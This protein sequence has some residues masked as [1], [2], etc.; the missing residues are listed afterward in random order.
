MN[1]SH[2]FEPHDPT[3]TD[4]GNGRGTVSGPPKGKTQD[5]PIMD[6]STLSDEEEREVDNPYRGMSDPSLIR[7]PGTGKSR[8]TPT[9]DPVAR[10]NVAV[11]SG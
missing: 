4:A 7:H 6:G 2:H 1:T 9:V 8:T 10:S 11:Q 3:R 5:R